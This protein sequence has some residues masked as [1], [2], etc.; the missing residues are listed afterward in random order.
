MGERSDFVQRVGFEFWK[1]N[2]VYP[3]AY[4]MH[5]EFLMRLKMEHTA[6]QALE[7]KDGRWH[8]YGAP[9][10]QTAEIHTVKGL[11]VLAP[12][13]DSTARSGGSEHG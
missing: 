1:N 3:A 7:Y 12:A 10:V 11:A 13:N 6:L 9:V 5:P 2:L 4:A 8:F